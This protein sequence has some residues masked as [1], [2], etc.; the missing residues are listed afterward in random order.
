MSRNK[1][2]LNLK[3]L[4]K[5]DRILLR[6]INQQN[7]VEIIIRMHLKLSNTIYNQ[8]HRVERLLKMVLSDGGFRPWFLFE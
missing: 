2:K 5:C 8:L 1:L 3:R 4:L 7:Q 6:T